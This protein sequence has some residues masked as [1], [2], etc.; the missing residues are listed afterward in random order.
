M[1]EDESCRTR[2][3]EKG[4]KKVYAEAFKRER[5]EE[6]RREPALNKGEEN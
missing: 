4:G 5:K 2:I 1:G 3:P 6:D